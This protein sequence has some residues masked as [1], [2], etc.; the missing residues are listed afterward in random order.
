MKSVASRSAWP[1]RPPGLRAPVARCI[2][3][4]HVGQG[5]EALQ[6]DGAR[7]LDQPLDQHAPEPPAFVG[8]VHHQRAHLAE[9]L[10]EDFERGVGALFQALGPGSARLAAT[11]STHG[12]SLPR[13]ARPTRGSRRL[14]ARIAAISRGR[15][16]ATGFFAWFRGLLG[17][18]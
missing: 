5:H 6:V 13:P 10:G 11:A 17:G 2:E 12:L 3:F 15:S 18:G 9:V 16:A 8:I 1:N 14:A 7:L 4:R